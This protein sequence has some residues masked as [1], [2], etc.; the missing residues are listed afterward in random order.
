[1]HK[2]RAVSVR[3]SV[4][5]SRSWILSYVITCTP[6]C[7][8]AGIVI[9]ACVCLCVRLS[10]VNALMDADYKF[11]ADVVRIF[12]PPAPHLGHCLMYSQSCVT[13]VS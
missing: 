2:R 1:M 13:V 11:F 4:C 6:L 7:I 10:V 5:L 3:P 9:T 8:E 12:V